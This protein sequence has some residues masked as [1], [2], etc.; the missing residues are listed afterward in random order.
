MVDCPV[1][2]SGAIQRE[3]ANVAV[4]SSVEPHAGD[5]VF[6][7]T[8]IVLESATQAINGVVERIG[9]DVFCFDRLGAPYQLADMRN[10]ELTFKASPRISAGFFLPNV[11]LPL[12]HLALLRQHGSMIHAAAVS[13]DGVAVVLAAW[14]GTGKTSTLIHLLRDHGLTFIADDLAMVLPGARVRQLGRTIN[15]LDYNV[16]RYPELARHF[17]LPARGARLAR[18]VLLSVAAGG[19]QRAGNDSMVASI[20]KRLGEDAKALANAKIP[21]EVIIGGAPLKTAP[22]TEGRIVALCLLERGSGSALRQ[23]KVN[24][25]DAVDALVAALEHEFS[26]L[27]AG[28]RAYRG[29][30][31]APAIETMER[32]AANTKAALLSCLSGTPVYRV[33][34][35]LNWHEYPEVARLVADLLKAR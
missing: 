21:S 34:L 20:A 25:H 11:L 1:A 22:G 17:S 2:V 5:V 26:K 29:L 8:D 19:S 4:T 16:A 15:V 32:F 18:R 14:G 24:L 3:L 10:T 12:A 9:D 13:R 7:F 27:L 28:Y 35:P 6:R 23:E 33:V 31:A 30:V